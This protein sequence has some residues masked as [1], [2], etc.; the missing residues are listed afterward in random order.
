[1]TVSQ[2]IFYKYVHTVAQLKFSCTC[3][4]SC[5]A[6]FKL[7]GILQCLYCVVEKLLKSLDPSISVDTTQFVS[8]K[9][10]LVT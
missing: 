3:S 8:V 10:P 9:P 7:N 1:V 4:V 6:C 5:N 2:K